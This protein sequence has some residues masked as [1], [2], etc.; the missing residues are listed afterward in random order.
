MVSRKEKQE[1]QCTVHILYLEYVVPIFCAEF[2]KITARCFPV[3][4]QM[5][6]LLSSMLESETSTFALLF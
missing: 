4:S 2:A 5:E 3:S 6:V 1:V